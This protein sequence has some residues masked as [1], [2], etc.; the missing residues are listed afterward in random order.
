MAAN[1]ALDDHETK[2][3]NIHFVFYLRHFKIN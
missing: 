1:M 2:M 3:T